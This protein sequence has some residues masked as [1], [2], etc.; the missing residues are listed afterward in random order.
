MKRIHIV[1]LGLACWVVPL[2]GCANKTQSGAAIGAGA[3]AAIGAG[4]GSLVHSSAGVGALI[5]AG[6]GALSGALVG[7]A[8]DEQDKRQVQEY[9]TLQP[10]QAYVTN[11]TVSKQDVIDWTRRG[12][13]TEVIA[14]RIDR[15]GT[16]FSLTAADEN[17]LRENGVKEQ[18]IQAMKQ[19]ARK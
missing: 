10:T 4:V 1:Q 14:D 2:A 17:M 9:R 18:V 8:M 12:V 3:G 13:S 5:G 19:T 11:S 16:R 7:N 15:S 6:A